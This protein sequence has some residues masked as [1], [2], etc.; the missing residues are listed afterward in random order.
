VARR[1]YVSP[2]ASVVRRKVAMSL[3]LVAIQ[4]VWQRRD[5]IFVLVLF[6]D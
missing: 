3:Q 1:R 5:T 4:P 2:S 6:V